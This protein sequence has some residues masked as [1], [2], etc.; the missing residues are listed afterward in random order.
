[1]NIDISPPNILP[2]THLLH[3][4]AQEE[5]YSKGIG[6]KVGPALVMIEASLKVRSLYMYIYTYLNIY[7]HIYAYIVWPRRRLTARDSGQRSG[8]LSL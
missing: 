2:V 6:P 3:A 7:L 1:V 4:M 8:Q 5:A